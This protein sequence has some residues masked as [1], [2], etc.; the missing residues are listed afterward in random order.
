MRIAAGQLDPAIP[1][2]QGRGSVYGSL[3]LAMRVPEMFGET[4]AGG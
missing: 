3:D 2:L 1:M 4:R